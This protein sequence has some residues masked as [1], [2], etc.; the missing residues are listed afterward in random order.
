MLVSYVLRIS[1]NVI[2]EKFF[3]VLYGFPML[4]LHL[5]NNNHFHYTIF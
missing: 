2:Q 5:L 3:E 4:I 1:V